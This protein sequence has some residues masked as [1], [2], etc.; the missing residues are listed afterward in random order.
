MINKGGA[1]KKEEHLKLKYR[2]ELS[3]NDSEYNILVENKLL[4]KDILKSFVMD[5][6]TKKTI[7]INTSKDPKFIF[8]LH[9][10]GNNINQIAK[11]ANSINDLS[12]KDIQKLFELLEV[13]SNKLKS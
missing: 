2:I 13:L 12:V 7:I 8:E 1:P 11:K 3:L 5:S 10:I 6:L 4:K 9:Q